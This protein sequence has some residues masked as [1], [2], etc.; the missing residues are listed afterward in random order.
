MYYCILGSRPLTKSRPNF[1]SSC[2]N[3]WSVSSA[4]MS[5][6]IAWIHISGINMFLHCSYLRLLSGKAPHKRLQREVIVEVVRCKL[7]FG[8]RHRLGLHKVYLGSVCIKCIWGLSWFKWKMMRR[9]GRYPIVLSGLYS[10]IPSKIKIEL[11]SEPKMLKLLITPA[12]SEWPK[13]IAAVENVLVI[14]GFT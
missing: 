2:W 9:G 8:Q 1:S 7:A 10:V 11:T 6:S 14:V 13:R 12:I 4:D 3:R 5:A